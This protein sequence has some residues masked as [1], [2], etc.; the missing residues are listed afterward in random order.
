MRSLIRTQGDAAGLIARL[1]LA[2][3]MFPHGAQK[4]LGWWG[5]PG[6][7]AAYQMFT[8]QMHIPGFFA[9]CA[10]AAEFLGAIALF[11]GVLSRLAAAAIGFEMLVAVALVHWKFGFFMN[12]MGQAK[13]E[14]FEYHLLLFALVA[15]VLVKGGGLYSFD[16]LLSR[17][18]THA[19]MPARSPLPEEEPLTV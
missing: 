14:G 6:L 13:G 11:F 4:V 17:S 8:A 12:W 16:R 19:R 1:G 10:I 2:V 9:G 3:V 15:V 5:G 7:H 18:R